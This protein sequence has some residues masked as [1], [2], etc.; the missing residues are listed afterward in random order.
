MRS[1]PFRSDWSELIEIRAAGMA[2]DT[3]FAMCD[4]RAMRIAVPEDVDRLVALMDEFYAA[5]GYK[6]NHQRASRAFGTMLA[7]ERLGR[8]WLIES[9]SRPVGYLGLTFCFSMEYGGPSAILDDFFIQSLSRGRGLG[10]AALADVRAF[11]S[12]G[13]RAINVETG[14]DNAVA[15]TVYRGMGFV[16]TDRQLMTLKLAQPSH[17]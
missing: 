6:L 14:F 4:G 16:N 13:V 2:R 11:K 8:V 10:K 5:G 3:V 15:Q 17:D 9:G 1:I 7:D 12:Y